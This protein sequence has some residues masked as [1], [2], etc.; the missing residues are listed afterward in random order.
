MSTIYLFTTDPAI[1]KALKEVFAANDML[2]YIQIAETGKA[3]EMPEE[4]FAVQ[5]AGKNEKIV[6]QAQAHL[7]KPV[8]LGAVIDLVRRTRI[9]QA[10]RR[11]A[12]PVKIGDYAFNPAQKTLQK[13]K[14]DGGLVRLTEKEADMLQFLAEHKNTV[15]T[16]QKLLE[17]IWGY[18][19]GVE[20][21]TLETHIYRLRQKLEKDPSKPQILVTEDEGYVLRL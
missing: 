14:G 16:R 18:N 3:G 15:V 13:R 20:T 11:A 17:D 21:H 8:R 12:A 9:R 6:E 10:A 5:I 7:Y 1:R 2:P 4:A 19:D